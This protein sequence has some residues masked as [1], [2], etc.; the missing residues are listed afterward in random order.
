MHP[1]HGLEPRIEISK[2]SE[3]IRVEAAQAAAADIAAL[4]NALNVAPSPDALLQQGTQLFWR[5]RDEITQRATTV[6]MCDP[7]APCEPPP[8]KLVS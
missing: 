4:L 6:H 8:E 3:Q 5:H 1:L 7:S 2:T